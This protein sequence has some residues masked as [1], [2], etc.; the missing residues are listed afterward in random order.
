[1]TL[2]YEMQVSMAEVCMGFI[3]LSFRFVSCSMCVDHAAGIPGILWGLFLFSF[4]LNLNEP[5]LGRKFPEQS[6]QTLGQMHLIRDM[7]ETGQ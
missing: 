5:I 2:K 1:M 6:L 3:F 4:C 7:C